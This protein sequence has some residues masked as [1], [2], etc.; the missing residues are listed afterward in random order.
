MW[1][2][3]AL[4]TLTGPLDHCARW[5]G[6]RWNV[7]QT[8]SEILT[9]KQKPKCRKTTG[10]LFEGENFWGK[11][12]CRTRRKVSEN[13][14]KIAADVAVAERW[15]AEEKKGRGG[16]AEK[17][18]REGV[19]TLTFA[20]V[21]SSRRP[22]TVEIKPNWICTYTLVACSA[23]DVAAD[24]DVADAVAAA[25]SRDCAAV[26]C[27]R[28]S[29]LSLSQFAQW[30]QRGVGEQCQRLP[31]AAC[32]LPHGVRQGAR[33]WHLCAWTG[34]AAEMQQTLAAQWSVWASGG[35]RDRTQKEVAGAGGNRGK[36][37]AKFVLINTFIVQAAA[38]AERGGR[39][40][41]SWSRGWARG[42]TNRSKGSRQP[43]E[44]A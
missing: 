29:K 12:F 4:R 9:R 42:R 6:V 2:Q 13:L 22:Q 44:Q 23:V 5:R 19:E 26:I 7:A 11:T 3:C 16:Q 21:N 18:W 24:G 32:N 15:A 25:A 17:V 34:W 30:V 31:H 36:N 28:P 14:I 37:E 39:R 41:C 33:K 10:K 27:V 1:R 43:L 20:L 35:E 8:A 38:A 40:G